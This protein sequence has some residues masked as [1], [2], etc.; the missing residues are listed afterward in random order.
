MLGLSTIV[1]G[2]SIARQ[3]FQ[4]MQNFLTYEKA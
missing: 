1:H 3:I 2:I 4:R